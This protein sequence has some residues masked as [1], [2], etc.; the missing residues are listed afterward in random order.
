[1]RIFKWIFVFSLVFFVSCGGKK[2]TERKK[3]KTAQEKLDEINKILEE[4]YN[5]YEKAEEPA[6]DTKGNDSSESTQ[7][8]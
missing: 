8:N 6:G 5:K 2:T 1:M 3:T 4:H 7:A